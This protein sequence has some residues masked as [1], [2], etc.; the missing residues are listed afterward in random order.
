[1][2]GV[3]GGGGELRSGRERKERDG[4]VDVFA[5]KSPKFSK[6]TNRSS[7]GCFMQ[8]VAHC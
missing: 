6:I 5:Q 4:V 3:G 2:V 1:M 7:M 8:S